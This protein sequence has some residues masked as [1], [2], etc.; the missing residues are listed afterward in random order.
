VCICKL[1]EFVCVCVEHD[2][3]CMYIMCVCACMYVYNVCGIILVLYLCVR[4][5]M[6]VCLR[7]AAIRILLF[8]LNPVTGDSN[9]CSLWT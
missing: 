6:R 1:S 7:V 2:Y 3:V 8:Y 5:S 4:V 9:L